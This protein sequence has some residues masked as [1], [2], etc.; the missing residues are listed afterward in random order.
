MTIILLAN[1]AKA[2]HKH[3]CYIHNRPRGLEASRY[4]PSP[5]FLGLRHLLHPSWRDDRAEASYHHQMGRGENQSRQSIAPLHISSDRPDLRH[6]SQKLADYTQVSDQRWSRCHRQYRQ[7][8]GVR[9]RYDFCVKYCLMIFFRQGF[10]V[11]NR[12]GPTLGVTRTPCWQEYIIGQTL[13]KL[14]QILT[15]KI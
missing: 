8:Q 15:R 5:T 1:F 7:A 12:L 9:L 3:C 14:L 10:W 6:T 11:W 2:C 4:W 13:A